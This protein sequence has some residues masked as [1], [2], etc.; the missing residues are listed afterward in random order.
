[1]RFMESRKTEICMAQTIRRAD[2]VVS[3]MYNEY[4]APLGLRATQFSVLRVLD[5][6]GTTTA[7]QIREVLVMD[8]T[9][10]SRT[11]KPLVRDGYV[12]VAQ[13]ATRR[14]K[15]LSL[16]KEGKKLYRQA[17]GP[18]QEAQKMFKKKLGKGQDAVLIELS[19]RVVTMKS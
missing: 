15:S 6:K 5:I 14:E 2:R 12:T 3:Q 19:R 13:G 16:S 8:Q 7:S 4:L 1:M 18:W 17:L 10:I 9:T 11:L